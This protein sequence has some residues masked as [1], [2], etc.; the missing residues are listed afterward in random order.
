MPTPTH[1]SDSRKIQFI[2]S[3]YLQ[4]KVTCPGHCKQPK[5]TPHKGNCPPT[6]HPQ[7]LAL[8]HWQ[9]LYLFQTL[10]NMTL[11]Q[12]G[13]LLADQKLWGPHA[14]IIQAITPIPL[15]LIIQM[16]CVS[17]ASV[18]VNDQVLVREKSERYSTLQWRILICSWTNGGENGG[19]F[20]CP[21][22]YEEVM[23]S[24]HTSA[25]QW[26][27]NGQEELRLESP[28]FLL[29]FSMLSFLTFK[30]VSHFIWQHPNPCTHITQ[31][32]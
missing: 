12:H 24:F 21:G 18:V 6:N 28:P 16:Y 27:I 19:C 26:R 22:Q 30:L 25:I 1:T 4:A 13:Y 20:G 9:S 15:Y 11:P 10:T 2:S 31:T 8:Q 3:W 5:P 29:L 7:N 14:T 23:G 32:F 17:M